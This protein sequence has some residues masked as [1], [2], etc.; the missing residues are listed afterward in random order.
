MIEP[1]LLFPFYPL[2]APA[3]IDH[4][5]EQ[6]LQS[7]VIQWASIHT[8]DSPE[9]LSFSLGIVEAEVFDVFD[10]SDFNR[11]FRTLVEKF[12][13]LVIDLINFAPPIFYAH[14]D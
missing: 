10:L 7:F 14:L 13:E 3:F 8:F 4:S 1:L 6:P 9:N 5:L 2:D 11:A 12:N